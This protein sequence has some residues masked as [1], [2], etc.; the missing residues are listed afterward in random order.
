MLMNQ[1]HNEWDPLQEVIIGTAVNARFPKNDIAFAALKADD[2]SK[3]PELDYSAPILPQWLL[4]ETEEDLNQIVSILESL[5]IKVMRP[6]PID[7][8]VNIRTPHWNSDVFFNYCPRDILLA[9]GDLIIETPG[10]NRSRYFESFSYRKITQKYFLDGRRWVS[11]P[12][13]QLQDC[14]YDLS[15]NAKII[16]NENE[17]IFDAAN[18]LR[19]G[20]DIFYLVSNS[21][22]YL[23]AK[24]LQAILGKEYTVHTCENLYRGVHI[25]STIALLKPGLM[26]INPERVQPQNLPEILKTWTV[27]PCPPMVIDNSSNFP[28]LSSPWL[29]MNLLM[30]TPE[31]AMVDAK[32]TPLIRILEKHGI[33]VI[34]IKLRHARTLGGGLH[35]ISLDLT[36]KGQLENYF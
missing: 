12:K 3:L 36:R 25:D 5:K 14:D 26:L 1:V 2:A 13:P 22:N 10:V 16:L 17:P 7:T 30:I 9:I 23:G 19:A 11:A 27:I 33:N 28:A 4:D 34:G 24:W 35:C 32:Q 18:V 29:G 8:T 20:K 6:E 15:G 31:L 21:G